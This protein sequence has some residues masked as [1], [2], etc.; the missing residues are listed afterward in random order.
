MRK[1]TR[2][3]LILNKRDRFMS[4]SLQDL[5]N[6]YCQEPTQGL[7]NAI[8]TKSMPLVRSI[9]GKIRR[10][11]NVLTQHEDLVSVGILGLLQ[12]LN[13]YK[14][15]KSI[16]FNTFAYYRIRGNIIDYLRQIDE[17]S[18]IK[19]TTYGKVQKKME[20]LMQRYGRK[21][22]DEEVARAMKMSLGEYHKLLMGVQQRSVL[23]L[24]DRMYDGSSSESLANYI[25]DKDAP[26]PDAGLDQ[27]SISYKLKEQ[28]KKLNERERLILALYYYEDLTLNEIAL[29]LGLSEARISQ[30]I[31]KLLLELKASLSREPA[32]D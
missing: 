22:A 27:E 29:L 15:E 23:S 11:D 26:L 7:R 32:M 13:N 1:N 6:A 28:I 4:R 19:R 5:V 8:I 17:V 3:R 21:P 24:D 16:Q 25:E 31:G 18:R 20:E 9:I 30:I 2:E 12:A 14:L 10:P